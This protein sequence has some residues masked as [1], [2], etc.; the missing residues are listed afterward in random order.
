MIA[1]Y[2]TQHFTSQSYFN[3]SDHMSEC[4]LQFLMSLYVHTLISIGGIDGIDILWPFHM[5]IMQKLVVS[6]VNFS[7]YPVNNI[8]N[9]KEKYTHAHE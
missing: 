1:F 9:G 4:H 8:F 5:K 7:I 2:L 3:N 6:N